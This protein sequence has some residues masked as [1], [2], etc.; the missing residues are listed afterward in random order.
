MNFPFVR[1]FLLEKMVDVEHRLSVGCSE[2]LQLGSMVAVFDSV[3]YLCAKEV[4]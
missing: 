4:S 2:K 3:R 1:V